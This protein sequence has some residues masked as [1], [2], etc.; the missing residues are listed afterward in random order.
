MKL[1]DC[2]IDKVTMFEK[3]FFKVSSLIHL[4]M[5]FSLLNKIADLSIELNISVIYN[6]F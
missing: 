6:L 3:L 5:K 1:K 4:R 2:T